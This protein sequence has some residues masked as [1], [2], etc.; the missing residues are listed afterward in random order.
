MTLTPKQ[1]RK[2][3][4]NVEKCPHQVVLYSCDDV[5]YPS[6]WV[7]K[8]SCLAC[9]SE[10]SYST[11]GDGQCLGA[12]G[13]KKFPAIFVL[14]NNQILQRNS[15]EKLEDMFEILRRVPEEESWM[16]EAYISF[17]KRSKVE[18]IL[19]NRRTTPQKV[20]KVISRISKILGV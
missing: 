7:E 20:E 11:G 13:N 18:G 2:N 16:G 5:G 9:N 19:I 12:F 17:R 10:D 1:I 4:E 15:Y 8:W 3:R 6:G 14:I